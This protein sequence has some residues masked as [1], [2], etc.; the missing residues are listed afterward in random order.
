MDALERNLNSLTSIVLLGLLLFF[1]FTGV[2]WQRPTQECRT[3]SNY[4][5]I[6]NPNAS[7]TVTYCKPIKDH[8]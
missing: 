3:Y 2:Q 7:P 1:L 8:V 6:E 4:K 5:W